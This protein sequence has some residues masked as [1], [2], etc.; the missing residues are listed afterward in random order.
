MK[1]TLW[2]PCI[3][4][5]STALGSAAHAQESPAGDADDGDPPRRQSRKVLRE[6]TSLADARLPQDGDDLTPP[7]GQ[8]DN[9]VLHERGF[10]LTAEER[11]F[12]LRRGGDERVP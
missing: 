2:T 1:H 8:C 9:R 4:L 11:D 6:E 7:V 5:I 3:L 12:G 10:P